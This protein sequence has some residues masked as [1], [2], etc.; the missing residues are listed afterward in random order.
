MF[1]IAKPEIGKGTVNSPVRCS[2]I[3]AR[4]PER[5]WFYGR[6]WSVGRP[7]DDIKQFSGVATK[8]S[9]RGTVLHLRPLQIST[10]IN[11]II[12]LLLSVCS[13]KP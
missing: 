13:N 2:Y 4:G 8:K 3:F 10:V 7:A 11:C 5:L 1:G 9:P 12:K 6:V